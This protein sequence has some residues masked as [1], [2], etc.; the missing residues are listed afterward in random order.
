M[1]EEDGYVDYQEDGEE[2]SRSRS[3]E[4]DDNNNNIQSF[5]LHVSSLNFQTTDESLKSFF[6]KYGEVLSAAVMRDP[7]DHRSRGFGF[8]TF[9]NNESIENVLAQ[10][11]LECDERRISIERA[12]R[13]TPH[14]KTPGRYAGTKRIPYFRDRD[15]RGRGGMRFD[16]R[17]FNRSDYRGNDRYDRGND[18]FDRGSDR[19]DRGNDRYDR[20]NDRYEHR[21]APRDYRSGGGGSRDYPV[22]P[23][24]A[25]PRDE[26]R[27]NDRYEPS[28]R[29]APRDYRSGGG[30]GSR[31]Y[32]PV[33]YDN[34]KPP[35][36]DDRRPSGGRGRF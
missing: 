30:G 8:V 19:F 13:N 12:K 26:Y 18:R 32:P 16:G 20:G 33:P 3:R 28:S 34:R 1:A 11:E 10:N 6:S 25:A 5:S 21:D 36:Y 31:D 24:P 4:R 9:S 29:D 7:I 27:S 35:P 22:A 2:R 23:Y 14:D 15:G 17:G